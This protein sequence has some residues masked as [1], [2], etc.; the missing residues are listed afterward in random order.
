MKDLTYSLLEQPRK[1]TPL[2]ILRRSQTAPTNSSRNKPSSNRNNPSGSRKQAAAQKN[3]A[4]AQK[5]P[6]GSRKN[7]KNLINMHS[8]GVKELHLIGETSNRGIPVAVFQTKRGGGNYYMMNLNKRKPYP[9][10]IRMNFFDQR[11]SNRV[12]KLN[13]NNKRS[14]NNFD[15]FAFTQNGVTHHIAIPI[16]Y[17]GYVPFLPDT[18]SGE[19][20]ASLLPPGTLL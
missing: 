20:R 12:R 13:R 3:Q 19:V 15:R 16:W 5:K 11:V 18:P 14:N 2:G 7:P 4:A 1:R 8:N 10:I 17:Q 9:N 6:S